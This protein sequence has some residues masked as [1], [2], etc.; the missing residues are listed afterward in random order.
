MTTDPFAALAARP[1]GALALLIAAEGGFPRRPGA[2]MALWPDGGRVGRLGGGFTLFGV[3]SLPP[4]GTFPLAD[5]EG[6]RGLGLVRRPLRL[7]LG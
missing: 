7:R 4:L 1:G 5:L 6:L 2:A 3:R